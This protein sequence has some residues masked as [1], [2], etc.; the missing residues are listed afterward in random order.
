MKVLKINRD[1]TL[2]VDPRG[3]RRVVLMPS[4][5]IAEELVTPGQAAAYVRTYNGC[6]G[7]DKNGKRQYAV[8]Q[9]YG[10]L[11]AKRRRSTAMTAK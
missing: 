11:A 6:L 2:V 9:S 1:G 4:G 10:R 3:T 8:A 7:P 5:E